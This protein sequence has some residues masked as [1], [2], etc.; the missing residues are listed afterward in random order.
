MENATTKWGILAIGAQLKCQCSFCRPSECDSNDDWKKIKS[1]QHFYEV[2][3]SISFTF[4]VCLFFNRFRA[5]T[6]KKN[7]KRRKKSNFTN[8]WSLRAAN[9][10]EKRTLKSRRDSKQIR[11]SVSLEMDKA[12]KE[13]QRT[14]IVSHL[15]VNSMQNETH[16]FTLAASSSSAA[17]LLFS[18]FILF[19]PV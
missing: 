14:K 19:L 16:R 18:L 2:K 11:F 4:F 5:T 8:K 6:Q 9:E 3:L 10:W 7:S 15:N 13:N 12:Q 1:N 17:A